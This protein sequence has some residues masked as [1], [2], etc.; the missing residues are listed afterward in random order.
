MG[1]MRPERIVSELIIIKG[2]LVIGGRSD[3]PLIPRIATDS[4][5]RGRLSR[6]AAQRQVLRCGIDRSKRYKVERMAAAETNSRGIDKAGTERVAFFEHN[7]LPSGM[8][9]EK[10]VV[11]AVGLCEVR[12]VK[13]VRAE[14][15]V[16]HRKLVIHSGGIEIFRHKLQAGVNELPFLPNGGASRRMREHGQR[17]R[18]RGG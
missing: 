1:P 3:T 4:H 13:Q 15:A 5:K 12:V 11:E 17:R 6:S 14:Q 16:I 18:C 10:N 7:G 9:L 2:V 8:G